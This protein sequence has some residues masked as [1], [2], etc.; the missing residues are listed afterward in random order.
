[1]ESTRR[2]LF[3]GI[4]FQW[5]HS[6]FSIG[7]FEIS[8]R[9]LC[10]FLWKVQGEAPSWVICAGKPRAPL[11]SLHFPSFIS[12]IETQLSLMRVF[13]R[14]N[15]CQKLN[16]IL[17]FQPVC[18]IISWPSCLKCTVWQCGDGTGFVKHYLPWIVGF[19]TP[20]RGF[21]GISRVHFISDIVKCSTEG[22][23]TGR[24]WKEGILGG[25]MSWFFVLSSE[26][27][28]ALPS[29]QV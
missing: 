14:L 10:I 16:M 25:R 5:E 7:P 28:V 11:P 23:Y 3:I 1:M 20:P 21:H 4:V 18:V 2:N 17:M 8:M 12:W 26:L 15:L 22:I 13:L 9:K 27:F 29:H 6:E 24:I 19:Q